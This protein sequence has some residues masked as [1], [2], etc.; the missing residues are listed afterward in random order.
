MADELQ[1]SAVQS[2]VVECSGAQSA[3]MVE[4]RG[5]EVDYVSGEGRASSCV[6]EAHRHR[7]SVAAE[8]G[9]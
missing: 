5:N 6:S 4:Q 1:R 2:G 8:R 3:E 7:P 9:R